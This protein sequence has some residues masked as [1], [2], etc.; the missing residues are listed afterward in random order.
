VQRR[1]RLGHVD[2]AGR[3]ARAHLRSG[4]ALTRYAVAMSGRCRGNTAS[5][6]REATGTCR[7]RGKHAG[8]AY[9]RGRV[10]GGH[11]VQRSSAKTRRAPQ[12]SPL[13]TPSLT[14]GARRAERGTLLDRK[15]QGA[16]R[17][18][19]G[20]QARQLARAPQQ[21][22]PQAA[23]GRLCRARARRSAPVRSCP[24]RPPVRCQ[25]EPCMAC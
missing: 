7:G 17:G 21:R 22:R 6:A 15:R 13:L 25:R 16:A 14:S 24:R 8:R 5:A 3:C 4:G 12:L 18:D 23:L 19:A 2:G 11:D 9:V 10:P 20:H 1:H